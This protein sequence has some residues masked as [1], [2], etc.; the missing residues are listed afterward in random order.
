MQ[1]LIFLLVLG[2]A[3]LAVIGLFMGSGSRTQHCSEN[4]NQY[5]S[6]E[7]FLARERA[8]DD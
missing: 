8:Q 5:E 2:L 3:V 4:E 1:T 7:D 6:D